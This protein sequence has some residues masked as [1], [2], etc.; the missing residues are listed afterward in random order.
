MRAWDLQ[1]QH[2][3]DFLPELDQAT[4]MSIHHTQPT[5]TTTSHN[6]FLLE[7]LCLYRLT[8]ETRLVTHAYYLNQIIKLHGV[9]V[10]HRAVK[11]S[12]SNPPPPLLYTKNITSSEDCKDACCKD[13]TCGVWEWCNNADAGCNGWASSRCKRAYSHIAT[14]S[15]YTYSFY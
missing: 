3:P 14:L 15:M 13:H 9:L 2:E 7:C 12:V 10:L 6:T 8:M 1:V 4:C 11:P 5:L